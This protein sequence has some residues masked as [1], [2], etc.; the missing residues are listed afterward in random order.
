MVTEIVDPVGDVSGTRSHAT[1]TK[2][3]T[4]TTRMARAYRRIMLLWFMIDR[5][6][7]GRQIR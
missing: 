3:P 7:R 2:D 6:S 4:R 5:E 1:V